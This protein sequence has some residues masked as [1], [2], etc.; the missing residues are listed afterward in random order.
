[1]HNG[2]WILLT[3]GVHCLEKNSKNELSHSFRP[4]V[5]FFG[6]QHEN[7]G[8]MLMILDALSLITKRY[9]GY[10]LVGSAAPYSGCWDRSTGLLSGWMERYPES[11]FMTCWPHIIRKVKRGEYMSRTDANFEAFEKDV[12]DSA[13]QQERP[14]MLK[15]LPIEMHVFL[16]IRTLCAMHT[17]VYIRIPLYT[18][19]TCMHASTPSLPR[20]RRSY[21]GRKL[22]S[23]ANSCWKQLRLQTHGKMAA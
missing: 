23:R 14:R 17:Q 19:A 13:C 8:S 22:K 18:H 6:K 7:S 20:V 16:C 10:N 2:K 3:A 4:V 9:A 11:K 5:H 12:Q 1:M 15:C 21:I